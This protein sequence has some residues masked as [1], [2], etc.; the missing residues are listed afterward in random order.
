MP[1]FTGQ[2][3]KKIDP[4]YFLNET[5]DITRMDT[6][7]DSGEL[8]SALMSIGLDD[9]LDIVE[10]YLEDEERQ[11]ILQTPREDQQAVVLDIVK[12]MPEAE[13]EEIFDLVD[14]HGRKIQEDGGIQVGDDVTY[15]GEV[16][17]VKDIEGD[18]VDLERNVKDDAGGHSQSEYG[19][20]VS[21]VE[22]A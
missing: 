3:K 10:P 7:Q 12:F 20:P 8:E 11:R 14:A 5:T 16:Y 18:K 19:V 4:R 2:N 21:S 6:L 17:Q 1:R 13:G 9:L 15:E 22:P